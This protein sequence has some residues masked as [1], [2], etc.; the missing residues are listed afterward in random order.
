MDP[1]LEFDR[2]SFYYDTDADSQPTVN[3]VSFSLP[4][5]QHLAILGANGS[6]K[7]TMARL[8]NGLL[9]PDAGT[10]T[11]AG[12]DTTDE[13]LIYEIRR[14]CGMVFQNPDNQI[15]ESTVALDVAFG[16]SNLG[17]GLEEIEKRVDD[18]LKYTGLADLRDRAPH[19]LSG[20]QKQK[21]A[22]AGV[23]AMQPSCI[24]LDEATSMLDPVSREELM[25]LI[26]KLRDQEGLSIVQITHYM[27]EAL[28]ADYV[29]LL[30]EG[31]IVR[32]GTPSEI[33]SRPR[34]LRELKLDV[35]PFIEITQNIERIAG[36]A[37]E[38][39]AIIDLE[40][41]A[42]HI[43]N[44][45]QKAKS[46]DLLKEQLRDEQIRLTNRLRSSRKQHQNS[47]E[48][49]VEINNLSY[50][51]DGNPLQ[52]VTALHDLTMNIK[53]G[54]ILGVAGAT[55]SGKS[56]FAQHLNGLIRPK[57]KGVVLVVSE[58]L[59]EKKNVRQIRR[60]VGLL[61]QYPEDQ[62]FEETVA[63][64]IA[65]GPKEMKFSPDEI[66][67][68][69]E[70]AAEITG[71]SHLLD[72]SP[73]ELSGGEKRR[74]AIAGVLALNPE[75]II[76]DEPSAGLDPEGREGIL[77]DLT[78]LSDRGKTIVLI[79]HDME[80][81]ARTADRLM[82]INQGKLVAIDT[83]KNIFSSGELLAEADLCMPTT[84]KFLNILKN[85]LPD[86][87]TNVFSA[88]QALHAILTAYLQISAT[89]EKNV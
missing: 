6:G 85:Y 12:M 33:F 81:V 39:A 87:Q 32:G 52:K 24:V 80:S 51:Y 43:M 59:F 50:T 84:I 4:R 73:F 67:F 13:D 54:E 15:I 9:L 41:A 22:I 69:V 58:D 77:R 82:I 28:Q 31:S 16:P 27:E 65:F 18:A 68:N 60:S 83:P 57:K 2:V 3:D 8:M 62:L 11:V 56:T 89:E 40:K 63:L 48:I 29:L 35:P 17:L 34:E 1:I 42:V 47:D 78:E 21:L 88:E 55:G 25:Q 38:P 70:Q 20:G 72:R 49:V 76:L 46:D 37:V 30:S 64:D 23:L 10:V 61:F 5:G 86:L 79:S 53:R 19:E 44:I 71:V 66:V 74:V 14:Q 45:L 7:S 36:E 26:V 75:I